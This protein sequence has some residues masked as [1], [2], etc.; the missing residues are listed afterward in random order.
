MWYLNKYG[1]DFGDPPPGLT[2]CALPS[3]LVNSSLKY[4]TIR[5]LCLPIQFPTI[6]YIPLLTTQPSSLLLTSQPV[7][8]ITTFVNGMP[9][10]GI[11]TLLL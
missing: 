8:V 4:A 6:P 10:T 3:I 1:L 7:N 2:V 9:V 5:P 11:L